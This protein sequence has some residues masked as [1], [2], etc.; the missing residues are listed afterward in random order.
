VL[1][2][3][4]IASS[5]GG[6]PAHAAEVL[7]IRLDGLQI[8]IRLDQLEAWSDRSARI[9]QA[10]REGKEVGVWLDLLEPESRSALAELL[11]APLL[12]D[13]S[14]GRQL[15]DSWAGGPMLAEVGGLLT[16]S[17]GESTTS[18]LQVTLR[19]LLEQRREVT[20]IE[21][22]RALPVPR[23]SLQ[24][25]HLISLAEQ[26]RRQLDQ[27]R[28]ALRKLRSYSLPRQPDRPMADGVLP[29]V[30][31]RHQG[32]VVAHRSEPL[33]LTHWLPRPPASSAMAARPWILMMPGLGG[34]ADHLSWLAAALAEGG[35]PV[36]V[37]QHPGSDAAALR[38]SLAGLRPPPGAE[39]LAVRLADAEAVL[40]AERQGALPLHGNGVVLMGHSLGGVTALLAAGL[41]PEPGRERR[42]RRALNR[43][44]I[45]NPSRLLQC[46]LSEAHLPR[47]SAR[48]PDLRGVVLLNGF[49]SLLWPRRALAPLAVPALVMGGSLDLVTPPLEEQLDLFLPPGDPRS[50]LVLVEGGSHFSPVRLS[51][52]EEALFRLGDELVGADP[53]GVQALLLQLTS[54]FL[55]TL[56]HPHVLPAQ[57]R[58]QGGVTAYVLDPP[59][60]RRWRGGLGR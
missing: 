4:L 40:A 28:L 38:A 17:E 20:A 39:T 33:P 7:E 55:Q 42:C 27:Q 29:A 25:D 60:A 22:L 52:P 50:R 23:L 21:L 9:S 56:E 46:Q 59:A 35:W 11:G 1:A 58:T 45:T 19:R 5:A 16:T 49:G 24:L 36:V 47:A 53:A 31:P 54:D 32:L 51:D 10:A 15:L 3:L 57:R 34:D 2:S 12:R 18:L 14:F 13:R 26:W 44:P 43:L 48:P 41:P 30:R 8:P 6:A 37:V